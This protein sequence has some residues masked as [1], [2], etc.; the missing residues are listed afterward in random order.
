MIMED[1]SVEIIREAET[2]E[3]ITRLEK[4]PDKLLKK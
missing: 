4:I 1:G 3:D 2:L